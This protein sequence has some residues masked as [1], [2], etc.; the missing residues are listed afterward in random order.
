VMVRV[1]WC[2]TGVN[3]LQH[4]TNA[5]AV[6]YDLQPLEMLSRIGARAWQT[7]LSCA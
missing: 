3:E 6:P 2:T 4:T 1:G 5:C 7:K